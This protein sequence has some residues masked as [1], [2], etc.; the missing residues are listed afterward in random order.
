M[1]SVNRPSEQL[2]DPTGEGPK[3]YSITELS[4]EFD[5]TPRTIR[6]Y[7]DLGLLQP[8][9]VGRQR[10]YAQGDRIRLGLILRGKRLGFSLDE[11]KALVM[12]YESPADNEPQLQAFLR[13][14]HTHRAHLEGQMA[15]I[16]ATL[17]ELQA[18]E[19]RCRDLLAAEQQQADNLASP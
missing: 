7:E 1:L 4:R 8:T 11:A 9:R 16:R 17:A 5:I 14:I 3:R 18:H 2:A 12:M 15:D 10:V 19:A 6:F 13:A